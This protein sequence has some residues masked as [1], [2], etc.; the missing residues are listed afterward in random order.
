MKKIFKLTGALN[1]PNRPDEERLWIYDP[2]KDEEIDLM[3]LCK[4]EDIIGKEV[5]ITIETLE[6]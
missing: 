6:K 1:F 3:T 2:K 5:R 4:E